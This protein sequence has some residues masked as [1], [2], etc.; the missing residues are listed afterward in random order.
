MTATRNFCAG[1]LASILV[2]GSAQAQEKKTDAETGLAIDQG[3]EIVKGYCTACHSPK[4][5]T[6][7]GKSREGWIE[8]IRWMQ[9]NHGLWDLG[10]AENEI[11]TYLEKNYGLPKA[12]VSR[13]PPLPSH[14]M[15]K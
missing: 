2:C 13:R 12:A 6:Q 14:L 9:R 10:S 11:L 4:L 8:S 7:S 3:F 15:P 1:L 5:I